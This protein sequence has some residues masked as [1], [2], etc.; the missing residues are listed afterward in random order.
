[1]HSPAW[2]ARLAEI[3]GRPGRVLC[4]I[5]GIGETNAIHRRGVDYRKVINHATAFIRTGGQAPPEVSRLPP[6]RASSGRLSKAR[7]FAESRWSGHS[8]SSNRRTT[9]SQ[10]SRTGTATRAA[11]PP[12]RREV[13]K[14]NESS[15]ILEPR[16]TCSNTLRR[17]QSPGFSLVCRGVSGTTSG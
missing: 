2:W 7:G 14:E 17:V 9:T 3:L 5:D 8:G 6:Q 4:A 13:T 16:L 1:M 15:W 12:T 11:S 10:D